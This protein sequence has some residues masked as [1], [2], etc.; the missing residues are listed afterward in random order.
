[1]R[2]R[3]VTQADYRAAGRG[4]MRDCADDVTR[5][6]IP[7]MIETNLAR[8]MARRADAFA[9]LLPPGGRLYFYRGD[10]SKGREQWEC[11]GSTVV[12]DSGGTLR[13]SRHAVERI[14][15]SE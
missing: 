9:L 13:V 14:L 7:V 4:L 15:K 10:Q 12:D 5:G 8:E 11:I 6:L 1:M 2:P 3:C